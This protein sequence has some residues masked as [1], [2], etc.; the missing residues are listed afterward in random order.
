MNVHQYV[1][2]HIYVMENK[3]IEKMKQLNDW[4]NN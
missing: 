3:N 1:M 4:F 2:Y